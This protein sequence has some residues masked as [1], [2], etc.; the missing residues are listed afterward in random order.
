[1]VLM[2]TNILKT[3]LNKHMAGR[4]GFEPRTTGPK[5]VVLPL[6]HRPKDNLANHS[7]KNRQDCYFKNFR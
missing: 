3:K 7:N 2:D 6:H 5:P 4:Q 1:M